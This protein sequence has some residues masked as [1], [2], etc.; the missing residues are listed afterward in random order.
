MWRDRR[1]LALLRVRAMSALESPCL[2]AALA[3][4]I[5]LLAAPSGHEQSDLALVGAQQPRFELRASS[6]E[7]SLLHGAAQAG[8]TRYGGDAGFRIEL[9]KEGGQVVTTV[10]IDNT[11]LLD[12]WTYWSAEHTSNLLSLVDLDDLDPDSKLALRTA[13]S[14]NAKLAWSKANPIYD[15]LTLGGSLVADDG[16]IVLR[17]EQGVARVIGELAAELASFGGRDVVATGFVKTAGE[18]EVTR[19]AELKPDTLE[20][21]SMAHCPFGKRAERAVIEFLRTL[22]ERERP[23]LEVRYIF[24]EKPSADAGAAPTYTALHGEKE[25]HESLV[26]MLIR[27]LLPWMFHDYLLARVESDAPWQELAAKVGIAP[28][29]VALI[30]QR[31]AAERDELIRAELDY[32]THRHAIRD[33]SPTYVWEGRVVQDVRSVSAFRSLT[34]DSPAATC[35]SP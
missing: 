22:P 21:F 32:A 14:V 12:V 8:V 23:M 3:G 35:S 24:Y 20:L 26:Q 6:L 2:R 13:Q 17:T 18:M 11:K 10:T 5:P 27:D 31:A 34:F 15:P 25:V 30:E 9:A 29:D 4:L 19:F 1:R 16:G 7:F 33:G 28:D